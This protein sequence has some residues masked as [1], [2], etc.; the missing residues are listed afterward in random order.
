MGDEMSKKM[1]I[2]KWVVSILIMGTTLIII[3]K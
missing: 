2:F 3:L 1:I